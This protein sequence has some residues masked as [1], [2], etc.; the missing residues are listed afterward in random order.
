MSQMLFYNQIKREFSHVSWRRGQTYFREERV[1]NVRLEGDL[2]V[3]QVQGT[4]EAPYYASIVM[5]RG[6]ISNSKCSCPAHR[7]Y[8]THCK[9]VAAL[10][11]WVVE[12]GA[13]L[14]V[15]VTEGAGY[16]V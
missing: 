11:I 15:G 3:G 16:G 2:V 6:T 10:S 14:R 13:L 4:G 8:E 7:V 12:R 5:A 1:Q 9:H